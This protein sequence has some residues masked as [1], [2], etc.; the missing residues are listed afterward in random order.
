MAR[1]RS[2]SARPARLACENVGAQQLEQ[3]PIACGFGCFM[4][5]V[6]IQLS[7]RILEMLADIAV[8]A[9]ENLCNVLVTLVL[10]NELEDFLLARRKKRAS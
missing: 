7:T 9:A 2:G 10:Q 1:A 6:R 3:L 8:R 5:I 4:T